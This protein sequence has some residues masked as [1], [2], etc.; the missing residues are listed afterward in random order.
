MGKVL[1]I[2][3]RE[4]SLGAQSASLVEHIRTSLTIQAEMFRRIAE[5]LGIDQQVFV[6]V[7]AGRHAH[8]LDIGLAGNRKE[9]QPAE[10]TTGH[11]VR[12]I[13]RENRGSHLF[14]SREGS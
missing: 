9:M 12:L 4:A 6:N 5:Y 14:D 10:R 3:P 1:V 2:G 11:V 8:A 13:G 7:V